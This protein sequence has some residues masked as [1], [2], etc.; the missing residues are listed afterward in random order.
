MRVSRSAVMASSAA[1][2]SAISARVALAQNA[3]ASA[4][5][6]THSSAFATFSGHL[7][8]SL[9]PATACTVPSAT[10]PSCT[11]RSARSSAHPTA[12]PATVS[13]NSWSSMNRGPFTFQCACLAWRSRSSMSASRSLRIIPI[14]AR[15]FAGKSTRVGNGV[16]APFG[17]SAA[18][19][20]EVLVS[21]GANV[22]V[23][24]A[25]FAGMVFLSRAD[26]RRQASRARAAAASPSVSGN[27]LT[28]DRSAQ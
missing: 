27:V 6:C 18:A 16:C 1:S 9:R 24:R 23:D 11:A 7:G 10:Q 4:T 20:V 21:D 2:A 14:A 22:L 3:S 13:N 5:T 19:I 26:G 25:R 17:T 28:S 8:S 15:V 12:R